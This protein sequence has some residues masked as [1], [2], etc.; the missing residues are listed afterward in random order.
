MIRKLFV[1]ALLLAAAVGTQAQR[2]S[3]EIVKNLDVLNSVYKEVD[4][5]YVDT[6]NTKKVIEAG[7]NAM[8]STLDPYTEYYSSDNN[9]ELK[10]MITG[11]YAGIGSGIMYHKRRN[12][13]VVSNPYKGMPAQKAGLKVGDELVSIDGKSLAGMSVDKVSSMLKGAAGTTFV[14]RVRRPGVEKP[15]DFK[16]TR[17]TIQLP[18]ISHYGMIDNGV[19]YLNLSQYTDNCAREVRRAVIEMRQNGMKKFVLDLRGNGGGSVDESVD[20]LSMFVEKG[21]EVVSTKG[22]LKQSCH[23]YKTS[24]EPLSLD[25]PVVVLVNSGTASAA[26]ITSGTLQDLDRAVVI[27]TRTYGKGLVQSVR[28]IP[29]GGNLKVTT[30]KYYI[31]SGRCIQAIDYKHRNEDGSVGRIP[32]SLTTVFHT[33][34]GRE[35]RDGGGI[36][37]DIEV[38]GDSVPNLVYYLMRE[39]MIFDYAV[40]YARKHQQIAPAEEFQM[41]DADY[42]EFKKMVMES[43]FKYD[44]QS[45]LALEELRKIAKY[46]GY[47]DDTAGEFEALK[48]KLSHD[49]GHDLE[50]FKKIIKRVIE[51]EIA[52]LY[53]YDEGSLVQQFRYDE[54]L[55]KAL[56]I[57]SSDEKYSQVLSKK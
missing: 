49:I 35:V 18:A 10:L 16:I 54:C 32:D 41:T 2:R 57:L 9:D 19:G 47:L 37:P 3:F 50:N 25:M 23:S 38:E 4:M 14:V 1:S 33:R 29:Y 11:K 53:Y 15:I 17:E 12:C 20:I 30:A 5:L 22:K 56:E 7:I 36:M 6:V 31:P 27:G 43:D 34:A 26:E 24:K 40:Q 28:N 51:S 52:R 46:E 39:N 42:D 21:Q 55:S 44:R 48:K 8:L 13:V 45:L